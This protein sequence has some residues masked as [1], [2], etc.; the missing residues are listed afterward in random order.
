MKTLSMFALAA[1]MVAPA[2]VGSA[3]DTTTGTK[4]KGSK[5]AASPGWLVIEE[6]FWTP[7]RFEPVESLDTIR[8]HYRR[9]EEKAAANEIDKAISWLKLAE[10]HAM[11][12][13]K[14]KLTYAASELTQ[15]SAKLRSGEVASAA[16]MDSALGRAAQALG[17][18]HFYKAKESWG[19]G[20]EQDAGRNLTMAANYLQHAADSAHLQ[21]GPDTTSVIT[22][23]YRY[24]YWTGDTVKFDHNK[25]GKDLQSIERAV[26]DLGKEMKNY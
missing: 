20:E 8:Y 26:S 4:T 24:G 6:D 12:I 19:K 18:W 16:A 21:F 1:L 3:A 25:L 9:N 22:D 5:P 7:L 13:T 14:E 17:E 23:Y 2:V 10:S 11:P 15:L